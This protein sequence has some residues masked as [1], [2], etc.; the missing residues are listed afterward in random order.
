MGH[1]SERTEETSPKIPHSHLFKALRCF[2]LKT[3][4]RPGVVNNLTPPPPQTVLP[5]YPHPKACFRCPEKSICSIKEGPSSGAQGEA[6]SYPLQVC[7]C[8]LV[9]LVVGVKSVLPPWP[10][11]KISGANFSKQKRGARH[12]QE[13]QTNLMDAR[14]MA[15]ELLKLSLRINLRAATPWE[16]FPSKTLN[17]FPQIG[18]KTRWKIGW[19]PRISRR[20]KNRRKLLWGEGRIGE[21]NGIRFPTTAGG[22]RT[23]DERNGREEWG[24]DREINSKESDGGDKMEWNI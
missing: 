7:G 8:W 1:E 20:Y 9:F 23:A 15:M 21:G 4:L 2:W 19:P 22:R 16:S 17:S 10:C 5:M 13:P 24:W 11:I 6:A 18:T 14:H 3:Q 12:Y